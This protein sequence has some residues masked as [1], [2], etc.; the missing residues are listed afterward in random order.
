MQD[1]I[2]VI[3]VEPLYQINLGYIARVAGNF[4][5]KRISIVSPRCNYKGKEA[6]KYSK[7]AFG[8]LKSAKIYKSIDAATKGSDLVVGTTG[9]W[10][11]SDDSFFNAY[12]PEK[13]RGFLK[14]RKS[15]SLL[16]G[17]DDIGL[18]KDELKKCDLTIVVPT[19]KDYPVLN[20]SHALAVILYEANKENLEKEHGYPGMYANDAQIQGIGK[21]FWKS[22]K[23]RK[24]IRNKK[25]VLFAFEHVIRRS[26]PTRKELN[27]VSIALSG[28]SKITKNHRH[29][30]QKRAL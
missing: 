20:I 10:H 17:R 3:L 22:I 16:I 23:E 15:I 1:A 7:H 29:F 14:R 26:N 19:S 21:L 12:P 25:A 18:T 4:G 30:L 13:A 2:K 11:K 5:V 8:L 9:L 28:M 27:A 6:I 24:D